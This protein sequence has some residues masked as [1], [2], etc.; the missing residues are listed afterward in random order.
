MET[1]SRSDRLK[2][3]AALSIVYQ[4]IT[5]VCGFII[6]KLIIENFGSDINGLLS[7]ISHFLGIIALCELGMGAV[8]PASLYKPIA[9]KNSEEISRIFLSS[10]KFFRK[11]AYAMLVYVCGM[12]LLYPMIISD[13]SNFY[14]ASLIIIIASSTF[15]QYYFGITNSL[16][17]NADQ[18]QYVTYLVNGSTIILNLLA[19]YFLIR[20]NYSIHVVKLVSSLIFIIRPLYFGYYVRCHYKIDR[21][22]SYKGEP[23]KQKWNGV[24]QHIAFAIQEKTGIVVL[25]IMGTLQQVSIYSIYFL[26]LEG[27]RGLIYSVTSSLTSYMGNLIAKNEKALLRF[28]FIYIE[29]VIHT[30]TILFFSCAAVLII[31]FVSVYMKG[32]TD[33]NYVM[34]VFPILMVA[35]IACRCLQM[36]YNI[37][38]QAAG[39]FKNTQGS[40]VIEPII[41]IIV[42]VSLVKIWG[43]NGVALGMLLSLIYRMVYLAFYLSCDI[44]FY[45]K[46]LFFKRIFIDLLLAFTIFYTCSIFSLGDLSYIAWIKLAMI[47]F[48]VGLVETLIISLFSYRRLTNELVQRLIKPVIC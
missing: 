8:V 37:V 24:A 43:L 14:T 35:A 42:S 30:I 46:R 38:I 19:T 16:L 20:F 9:E 2:L 39:H 28:S 3:N 26:I 25:S 40:A 18:K 41:N 21:T 36:P 4:L 17:I 6:P 22:I 27:L 34:S 7:S 5:I 47:V 31:P 33:A 11:I 23:I 13:Y 32:V 45:S 12:T 48:I 10:E 15:A 44:I 1:L 29:F